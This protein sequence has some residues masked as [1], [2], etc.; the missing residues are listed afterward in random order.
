[1]FKI[2]HNPRCKKSRAGL[3]YLESKVDNFEIVKYLDDTLSSDQLKSLIDKTGKKPIEIIRKQEDYFKKN[4]KGKELSDNEL[5]K[6]MAANPK[7]IARPI[8]E[9][10]NKAVLAEPPEEI[11]KLL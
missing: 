1:M 11:D 4:M 6:E 8:V 9:M 2:Y 5:I 3:A 10:G 7:L